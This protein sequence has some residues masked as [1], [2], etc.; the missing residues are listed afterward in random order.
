MAHRRFYTAPSLS[1]FGGIAALT[2]FSGSDSQQDVIFTPNG[3]IHLSGP[4]SEYACQI[5][6]PGSRSCIPGEPR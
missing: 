2:G 4:S 3:P 5:P 1:D 6:R